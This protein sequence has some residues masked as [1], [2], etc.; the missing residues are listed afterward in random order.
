MSA[1]QRGASRETP[2]DVVARSAVEI[3]AECRDALGLERGQRLTEAVQRLAKDAARLDWLEASNRCLMCW[4]VGAP[5]G[6]NGWTLDSSDD[7]D[8][9]IGDIQ[10]ATARDVIDEAMYRERTNAPREREKQWDLTQRP[11]TQED[12]Q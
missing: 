6:D 7:L 11:V 9:P 2:A 3:I 10:G 8:A 4:N 5:D 12:D 1:S